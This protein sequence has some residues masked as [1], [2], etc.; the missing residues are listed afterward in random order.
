VG[1]TGWVRS[2]AL[3]PDGQL[4]ASGSDDKTVRVWDATHG[5]CLYIL[6]GRAKRVS[7]VAFSPTGKQLVSGSNDHTVR[8]WDMSWTFTFIASFSDFLCVAAK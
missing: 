8:V 3:S 4:L 1:H 6:E 5:S 7:S 2:V